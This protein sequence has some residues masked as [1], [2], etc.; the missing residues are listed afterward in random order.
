MDSVLMK[1]T[2]HQEGGNAHKHPG[3]WVENGKTI[4]K[5]VLMG[6]GVWEKNKILARVGTCRFYERGSLVRILRNTDFGVGPLGSNL[7]LTTSL[8][9]AT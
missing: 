5:T 9:W 3:S 8:F 6:Y 4:V 2:I 1:L 7:G